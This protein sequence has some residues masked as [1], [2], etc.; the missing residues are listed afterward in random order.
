MKILLVDDQEGNRY[1]A[2]VLLK[3]NGYEVL[4]AVN[5]AEALAQLQSGG[6][7]DLIISDILMPV[8][9]G[10]ELCRR[11]K[12]DE[13]LRRIPF[14]IYTA[15]YTSPEDEDF[16]LKIGAVGFLL[17]PCEPDAFMEAVRDVIALAQRGGISAEP[18]HIPEEDVLKLYSE[19]LVC[20][21]EQK[22]LQL[23]EETRALR[24]AEKALSISEKKYRRL[25]ES[26]MDGYFAVDMRGL[27]RESNAAFRDLLGYTQEELAS[28][29]HRD[30]TP[31]RWHADN[32][33]ILINQ[34]LPRGYSDVYE[35]E[36]RR[37]DG[38]LLPVEVRTF[39]L[40]DDFGQKEGMWAIVR[41]ITKRKLSEQA[42]KELEE[43]LYQ[44]QK[45]ESIGRL[46][47]GVAH[48]YNNMLNVILGYTQ[49][50]LTKTE[51]TSPVH[52]YLQKILDAGQRSASII[53]Q[54][55]AFA[56][57]QIIVP[58]VFDLNKAVEGML[59]ML[60]GVVGKG[61]AVKWSPDPNL[62]QVKLDPSQVDQLL[63]NLCVNSRDAISGDGTISIETAMKTVDATY[64]VSHPEAIA[65]EYCLLTVSDD[66]CGMEQELMNKIFEPFF[67]TK[68]LGK[69]TGLGLA[70][71]YGIV[72]QNKG[73]VEVFSELCKGTTFK[74][75]LPRHTMS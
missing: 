18:E 63:A 57:K 36:Y 14:L 2:E 13:R 24:E 72:K 30:L 22:M 3:G 51:P 16:A 23:E 31:E 50:A 19:R 1:F 45:M 38:T 8:M 47:G 33:E 11:V 69:G 40:R 39:L 62:C 65:G 52:R 20:K 64:C 56:R 9:D 75:Y 15:T 73:F 48:D 66:G 27:I 7:F 54:L 43:Q 44:A 5:G 25:H 26:M 61:I 35:K 59:E 60:K 28:L 21:L 71:V 46:A 17:K 29:T 68:E 34:V 74:I 10:F 67:T 70:T 49:M 41:D 42:R 32:E 58:Q 53:R 55:L 6:P 12:A 4:S 37:K